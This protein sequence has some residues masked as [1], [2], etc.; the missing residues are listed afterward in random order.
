LSH[1]CVFSFE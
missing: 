1:F